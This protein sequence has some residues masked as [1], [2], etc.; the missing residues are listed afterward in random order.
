MEEMY[1]YRW[2]SL[3]K[4]I[5]RTPIGYGMTEFLVPRTYADS[6]NL[7]ACAI[8]HHVMESRWLRDTTYLHQILRTWYRG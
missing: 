5:E 6:Y 3:R 2:W 8:G 4:H 7:I 1:Y